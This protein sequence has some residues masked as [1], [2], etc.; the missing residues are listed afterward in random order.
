MALLSTVLGVAAPSLSR[1]FRGRGLDSETQRFLALTRLAQSRAVA[2]G[3]PMIVWVDD[4]AS[5]YGLQA[6]F[7]Y[8][9]ED[10]QAVE[11]EVEKDL[12]VETPTWATSSNRVVAS[13]NLRASNVSPIP[14]DA[15]RLRFPPEGFVPTENPPWVKF[16]ERREDATGNPLWVAQSRNGR[17]Y[18]IWTNEPPLQRR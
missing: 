14:R 12:Q 4:D 6:E 13:V 9:D 17:Q 15:T 1:F 10:E 5:R 16:R 3:V 11:F 7:T 18:E 2:E 8:T